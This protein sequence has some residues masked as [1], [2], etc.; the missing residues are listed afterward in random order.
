MFIY[1]LSDL[2]L[3]AYTQKHVNRKITESVS[4]VTVNFHMGQC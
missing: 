1:P 3:K 2:E 4:F